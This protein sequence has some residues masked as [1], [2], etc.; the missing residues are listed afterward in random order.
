MR[1][2]TSENC[3]SDKGHISAFF[4][5]LVSQGFVSIWTSL[6]MGAGSFQEGGRDILDIVALVGSRALNMNL[7]GAL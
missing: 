2:M 5:L 4:M 1:V 7:L 6:F 3:S